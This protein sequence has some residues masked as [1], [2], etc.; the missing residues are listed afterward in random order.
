MQQNII[1]ICLAAMVLLG[2][3]A[4]MFRSMVK[5]AVSLAGISALL[6]VVLFLM[7]AS[8][9]ALFELSVCAGLVT[10]IFISAISLTATDRKQPEKVSAHKSRFASLPFILIFA[11]VAMIALLVLGGFVIS[12]AAT[13]PLLSGTFTP[14]A[15]F[16]EALWNM[17]QADVLGQIIIILA[18]AFAVVIL[19]REGGKA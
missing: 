11:G 18:G 16:K 13:S 9:A 19:F 15:T 6:A 7:G 2:L 3:A 12:P 10:A 17:R 5:A 14:A 1:V 8:W 4:A